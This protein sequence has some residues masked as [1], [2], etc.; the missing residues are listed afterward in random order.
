MTDDVFCFSVIETKPV[1]KLLSDPI[2][3]SIAGYVVNNLPSNMTAVS[4]FFLEKLAHT[5]RKIS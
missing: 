5:V 4:S 2:A 3:R 1:K